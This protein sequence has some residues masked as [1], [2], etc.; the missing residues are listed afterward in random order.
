M[1]DAFRKLAAVSLAA[2]GVLAATGGAAQA[3]HVSAWDQQWLKTSIEG[4]RFEIA[5]GL[6]AQQ[7]GASPTVRALGARLVKDHTKSLKDASKVA[8]RLGMS[9]PSKPTPSMQWELQI[10][11]TLSG[12]QFD[13]WYSELEIEDHKQ[14]ISE[15][16]DE[17]KEGSN[18]QIRKLAV[19]D[20]PMLKE[21]LKLS[22]H[23]LSVSP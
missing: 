14:D 13:H 9:V 20:L 6:L 11:G 4:D 3:A 8:R 15:S 21:H 16:S 17:V 22:M 5:G 1:Y 18:P 10:V 7:K 12:S 23:A 19:E 2:L